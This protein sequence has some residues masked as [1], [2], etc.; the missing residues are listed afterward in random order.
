MSLLTKDTV[1]LCADAALVL[2]AMI[3]NMTSEVSLKKRKG[4]EQGLKMA[5]ME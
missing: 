5:Q 1:D 3:R 2:L 4:D